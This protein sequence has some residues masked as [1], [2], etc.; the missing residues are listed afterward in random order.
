ML[1]FTQSAKADA[2]LDLCGRTRLGHVGP[3]A[4]AGDANERLSQSC[5]LYG[6]Q[7]RNW[8]RR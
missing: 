3:G 8:Y 7:A 1:A 4:P 6:S 5:Q 2:T